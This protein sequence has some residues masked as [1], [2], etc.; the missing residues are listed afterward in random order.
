M[1]DQNPFTGGGG[2]PEPAN[3][4]MMNET[5]TPEAAEESSESLLDDAVEQLR[6]AEQEAAAMREAYLRARADVE[7]IRRQAQADVAKAHRYGI[8]RFAESLLPVKDALESALSVEN[9]T[10]E[11]LR[12]GVELTLKQLV[13]AFD[14]AQ[15]TVIDPVGEKFDPHVHQA[16]AMVDSDQPANTVV[17]VMQKGYRLSDR[18][19]RPAMV[20]VTKGQGG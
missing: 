6:K 20:V 8:E 9:A 2:A 12:A 19:L 18:V 1:N 15:L 14:K 5:S 4:A 13:A 3:P 16:M 17:Q 10:P 11:S 7:N